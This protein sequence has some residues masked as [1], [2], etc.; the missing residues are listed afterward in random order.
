M[1]DQLFTRQFSY[2]M[3]VF[4]VAHQHS[5]ELEAFSALPSENHYNKFTSSLLEKVSH[6]LK[7]LWEMK[8]LFIIHKQ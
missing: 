6:V 1:N 4:Q 2:P 3:Q 5:R 7:Y 8:W